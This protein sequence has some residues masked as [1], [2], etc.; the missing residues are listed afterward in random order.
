MNIFATIITAL[1]LI[2]NISFA[3]PATT[4][5]SAPAAGSR[6]YVVSGSVFATQGKNPAHR[7]INSEPIISDTLI[8]TGDKSTALL[9]FKD[10][11]VVTIQANSVFHVRN[12]R[13]DAAKISNSS[14]VFSM[15]KGG[16]RF[17]TGLIGQQRKQAFRLSTPNAT[18][19][20][21]GTEFMVAMSGNKMYSQVLKGSVDMTNAGGTAVLGAGQSAVVASSGA[22]ATLIPASAIPSG[23]FSELLSIPLQPSAI[24]APAAAPAPV[25]A[26]AAPVSAPAAGAVTSAAGASIAVAGGVLAAADSDSKTKQA[27]PQPAKPVA[28]LQKSA[29]PEKAA[30]QI[31]S[32]ESSKSGQGLTAKFG[33]LGY[34]AELNFELSD[35]FSTRVGASTYKYNKNANASSMNFDFKLRLQTASALADWYPFEGSFRAS[36]GVLY[37]NN[38]FSLTAIPTGGNFIIN[39]VTYPSTQVSSLKGTVTFNKVAPYFGIGWGNPVAK[40]K[41]WGLMSDIGILFQGKPK[42]DLLVTCAATCPGTLPADAAAENAKLQNDLNHFQLWP[43]ASVGITYQW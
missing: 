3:A 21:R 34:G 29:Q 7:V 2:P 19:G 27:A 16:M 31:K 42:L 1:V 43:V 38:Q 26:P 13:Y 10:G 33:T 8:S 36:G 32:D 35:S 9:R 40:D 25:T 12:Y 20:I 37:N 15:L 11:E 22:L 28:D 23:L 30:E 18:I 6:V 4:A 24:P 41:G 17:I 14:I 39:G 5:S